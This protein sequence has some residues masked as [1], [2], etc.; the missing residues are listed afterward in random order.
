M[1]E[2]MCTH[3]RMLVERRGRP[4]SGPGALAYA[5]AGGVGT[6]PEVTHTQAGSIAEESST[7]L[8]LCQ[9]VLSPVCVWEVQECGKGEISAFGTPPPVV[10]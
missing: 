9:K 2:R 5:G 8:G 4:L 3:R 7:C 6:A 10:G 1:C